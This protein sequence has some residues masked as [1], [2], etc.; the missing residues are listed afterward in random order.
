MHT[1]LQILF[2]LNLGWASKFLPSRATNPVLPS[3]AVRSSLGRDG[4]FTPR[5]VFAPDGTGPT[6]S[7][8]SGL[9]PGRDYK[10]HC[11]CTAALSQS[12]IPPPLPY[13]QSQ[14]WVRGDDNEWFFTSQHE[15]AYLI[16]RE[17]AANFLEYA[18]EDQVILCHTPH[19]AGACDWQPPAAVPVQVPELDLVAYE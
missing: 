5:P 9:P 17:A 11:W 14:M 16:L 4:P 19:P 7:V 1:L 12:G 15:L 13:N 6:P 2:L 18:V 10:E 3:T 8:P